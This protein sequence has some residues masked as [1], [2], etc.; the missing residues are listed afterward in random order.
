MFSVRWRGGSFN[1]KWRRLCEEMVFFGVYMWLFGSHFWD[2]VLD[3][4][5]K[6]MLGKIVFFRVFVWPFCGTDGAPAYPRYDLGKTIGLNFI[7]PPSHSNWTLRSRGGSR[8]GGVGWEPRS[9][10]DQG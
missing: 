4:S 8:G 10:G 7:I 1:N 9:R 2:G 6:K 3:I 5:H